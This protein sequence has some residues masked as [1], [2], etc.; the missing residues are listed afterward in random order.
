MD[1]IILWNIPI[2]NVM[3]TFLIT[4]TPLFLVY[5]LYFGLPIIIY[6]FLPPK[7]VGEIV[8]CLTTVCR[9]ATPKCL[10]TYKQFIN[11]IEHTTGAKCVR[12]E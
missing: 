3:Y 5:P 6:L 2:V 1:C 12:S 11:I 9:M 10:T 7:N 8:L 4:V